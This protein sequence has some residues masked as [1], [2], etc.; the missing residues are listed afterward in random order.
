MQATA[1]S[2]SVVKSTSTARRRLIRIVL[3]IL[4]SLEPVDESSQFHLS[5]FVDHHRPGTWLLR[6][7]LPW[8]LYPVT[9]KDREQFIVGTAVAELPPVPPANAIVFVGVDLNV[10]VQELAFPFTGIICSTETNAKIHLDALKPASALLF[11][12]FI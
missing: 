8:L 7:Q 5:V 6:F 9:Q 3:P 1:R 12:I 10:E 4:P 2:A 11:L